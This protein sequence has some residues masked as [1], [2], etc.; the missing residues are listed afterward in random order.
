VPNRANAK[1]VAFSIQVYRG[2][3]QVTAQGIGGSARSA[4]SA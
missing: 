2:R 4:R 3:E 1:N